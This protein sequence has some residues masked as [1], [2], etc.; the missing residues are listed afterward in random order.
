MAPSNAI[1]SNVSTCLS[2][3]ISPKCLNGFLDLHLRQNLK[4]AKYSLS[5]K[6]QTVHLIEISK[7][8]A[9][10]YNLCQC[11][12]TECINNDEHGPVCVTPKTHVIVIFGARYELCLACLKNYKKKYGLAVSK[13]V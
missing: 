11:D 12:L 3:A 7:I 1:D 6:L 9:R 2:I 13:C 10:I 4:L 5:S 8:M